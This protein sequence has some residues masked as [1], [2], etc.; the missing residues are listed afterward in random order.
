MSLSIM[1]CPAGVVCRIRETEEYEFPK[2]ISL[3]SSGIV[4]IVQLTLKAKVSNDLT[5]NYLYKNVAK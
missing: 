1:D 4:P 2:H 3:F 5:D